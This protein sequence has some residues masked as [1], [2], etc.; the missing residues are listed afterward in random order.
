MEMLT[1]RQQQMISAGLDGLVNP[2]T[3]LYYTSEF[4]STATRME[5]TLLEEIARTSD[6]I[7]L[8]VLADR[9]DATR[10]GEAGIARTPAI[11]L[12]GKDDYGIRYYGIPD[13]YELDTFLGVIRAVSEG[14]SGL[15]EASRA[16][17][18]RLAAP[19]HLEVLVAPT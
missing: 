13:G 18:G 2:V 11:V 16:A 4:A 7:Q 6:R 17:V 5:Q 12:R 14:R 10:E 19:V 3:V 15:S 8:E 1:G 9:W